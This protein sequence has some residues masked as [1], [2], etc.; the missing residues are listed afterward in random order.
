MAMRNEAGVRF[1]LVLGGGGPVGIAWETGVLAG[2]SASGFDPREAALIVGTSAGS[3]VGAQVAR[4]LDMRAEYEQ[5]LAGG[6]ERRVARIEPDLERLERIFT[7]WGSFEA[8]NE[9]ACRAIG[10]LA[11]EARTPPEEEFLSAFV[12]DER[13]PEGPLVTTAVACV[14]GAFAAFDRASGVS[15]RRAVAASCA[16]P[17]IF[18]PVTIAG[19]RYMDG[20]VRS[21]TNADLALRARPDATLIVAPV[22]EGTSQRVGRVGSL[23][24]EAEAQALRSAGVRTLIVSPGDAEREAFGP[25]LMD[26]SRRRPAAEAG[27]AQGLRVAREVE[28]LLGRGR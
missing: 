21:V 16:V 20:G 25:N 14:S 7:L 18:P 22:T 1:A 8:M 17:G 19:T 15:L 28:A 10:A 6:D 23:Q 3:V 27:Y 5:M 13:W 24:V 2:L 26:P 11:L 4:G 9:A 12:L